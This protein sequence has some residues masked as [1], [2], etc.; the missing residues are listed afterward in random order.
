MS[1]FT[2]KVKIPNAGDKEIE[3]KLNLEGSAE[4]YPEDYFRQSKHREQLR[5][6]IENA[7][8]RK[9]NSAHLQQLVESWVNEIK[10][11]LP[12]TTVTLNLPPETDFS[13]AKNVSPI[14]P[15]PP[16]YNKSVG[17]DSNS[18]PISTPMPPKMPIPLKPKQLSKPSSSKPMEKPLEPP[19]PVNIPSVPPNPAVT[20]ATNPN[21]GT[22]K[23]ASKDSDTP[24][25]IV[26][27]MRSLENKGDF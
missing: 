13:V 15:I 3:Y 24:D 20:Q 16:V 8:A 11:G 22:E 18:S 14:K 26:T 2:L 25:E 10:Q 19:V 27:E 23:V 7:S 5:V 12:A 6:A 9:L 17:T 21:S 1:T 4:D